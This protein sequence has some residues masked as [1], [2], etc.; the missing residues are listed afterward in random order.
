MAVTRRGSKQRCLVTGGSGFLGRHLVDQLVASGKFEVTVFDIRKPE[1]ATEGAVY[2][3][4]DLRKQGEVDKACAGMDVVFHCATAALT[5]SNAHNKALMTA[6]NVDGTRHVVEACVR[7]RVPRLVYTSSASVVFEGRDLKGVDETIPYAA[8][9]P[10]YYTYTKIEGERI[11]LA[12]NG[13]GGLATCA[14]R[15]SGIF[16]EHD[17]LLVPTTVAKARQGKMKYIVGSGDNLMDWTYA[18]NV[19]Q[20]HIQAAEALSLTSP[21]AGQAYFVTNNEDRTFWGFMGDLCEGLGYGRPRIRLPFWLVYLI[22]LVMQYVITPLLRPFKEIQTDF[23]PS[24][25]LVATS[26]RKFSVAKAQRDFG[27]E[28]R[29]SLQ[30]GLERTLEHFQHLRADA[31][32][33]GAKSKAA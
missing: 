6:V 19:A 24:R 18:G 7:G 9:P 27:Y 10:D 8:K 30:E 2:V 12:A 4:G 21:L 28:P 23:T 22:A 29:V 17:T 31:G 13:R 14:L 5:A 15:P 32:S 16:G 3:V 33:G 1:D 26:H 11:V 25:M 20:A